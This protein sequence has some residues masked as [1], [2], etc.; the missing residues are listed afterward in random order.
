MHVRMTFIGYFLCYSYIRSALTTLGIDFMGALRGEILAWLQSQMKKY[1]A[2]TQMRKVK[3]E[4]DVTK[5]SLLIIIFFIW[6]L[7]QVRFAAL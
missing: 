7:D 2:H 4:N 6:C 1:L 5:L 3:I